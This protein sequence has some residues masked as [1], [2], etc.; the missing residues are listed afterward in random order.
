MAAFF[1]IT[2]KREK[3]KREGGGGEER[4]GKERKASDFALCIH[5]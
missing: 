3:N 4:K 5:F 1:L 2:G